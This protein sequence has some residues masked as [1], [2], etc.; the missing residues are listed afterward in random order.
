M[1]HHIPF[2]Q[3]AQS[4]IGLALAMV[5]VSVLGG[6]LTAKADE[7]LPSSTP[8]F[9]TIIRLHSDQLAK[10]ESD[11]GAGTLFVSVIGPALQMGDVA[12]TLG[13]NP[14]PAKLAKELLMPDLTAAVLRLMGNLTAWNLASTVRQA[15]TDQQLTTVTER[16]FGSPQAR[17]WLDQQEK[18]PWH[19]SLRQLSDVVVSPEWAKGNQ[20]ESA[21]TLLVTVLEQATRLEVEAM[22]A[23]YQEWDRIRNWK[24]RVR[25]LRGQ[26]RLCGT[27]QWIVHNHQ[28][29]HREQK[30]TL[31][32]PPAGNT[33]AIL[34]GL[35]ETIVLGENVYLRWEVDGRVQEDSLQ[36]SNEGQRLEG[37]FVNSQ[38]G[39]GSIS[40]KK[41]SGCTP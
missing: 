10:I 19:D 35:A 36:F 29:Q 31:L 33:Q 23:G 24:D 26:A 38:G 7:F 39:W 18:S 6:W 2:P 1:R 30:L 25:G 9:P 21:S 14:L 22:Q 12:R 11:K 3:P 4:P 16:L 40:G 27:W 17:A 37:T 15:V 28:Q 32:F 41:T 5:I 13:A 20:G 34:P 8:D